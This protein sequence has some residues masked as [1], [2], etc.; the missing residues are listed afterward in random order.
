[1]PSFSLGH[2]RMPSCRNVINEHACQNG[3]PR[4]TDG[5]RVQYCVAACGLEVVEGLC[6]VD[7]QSPNLEV[8]V[9][10]DQLSARPPELAPD[11]YLLHLQRPLIK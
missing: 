2:A 5:V 7:Y 6:R 9:L 1:M 8:G 11:E 3:L 10:A 4:R